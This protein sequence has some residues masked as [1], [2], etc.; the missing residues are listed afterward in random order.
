M[1]GKKQV[2]MDMIVPTSKMAL[3]A[4]C[5]RACNNDIDKATK[6][7]DFFVKDM[8]SLPDFDVPPPS[9]MSQ[10][11]DFVGN[12]VGWLDQNQDKLMGYYQLFQQLR[13]GQTPTIGTPPTDIPPI[14]NK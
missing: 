10:I 7:Y 13:G 5:I 3:K 1:F 14:P 2:N 11:R 6:L 4:S 9:T 8:T 12:A